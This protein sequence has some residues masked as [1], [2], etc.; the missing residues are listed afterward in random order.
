MKT[1]PTRKQAQRA[2]REREM[3]GELLGTY[4]YTLADTLRRDERTTM[5]M[6]TIDGKRTIRACAAVKLIVPPD[7]ALGAQ[8]AALR[9]ERDPATSTAAREREAERTR[10]KARARKHG[11][12]QTGADSC[13]CGDLW[14]CKKA[15]RA[16]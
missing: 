3:L 7:T 16:Q 8:I 14:P 1:K 9:K 4:G 12:Y 13:A 6:S 15:K 11:H 5:M 10:A 2:K